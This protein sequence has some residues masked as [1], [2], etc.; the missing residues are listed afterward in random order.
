MS[1]FDKIYSGITGLDKAI[2]F[3]RLGDNVV[4]QVTDIEEYVFFAK[5]HYISFSVLPF[6]L[7]HFH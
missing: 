7:C 5:V 1:S 4:W 6:R 3:I 2:D